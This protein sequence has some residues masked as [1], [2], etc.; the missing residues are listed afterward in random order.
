MRRTFNWKLAVVLVIATGLFTFGVYHLWRWQKH[1]TAVYQLEQGNLAYSQYDWSGAASHYG[2]YLELVKDDAE[3][4]END[5]QLEQPIDVTLRQ[6]RAIL[7]LRPLKRSYVE[8]V[9]AIYR[10][11]LRMD[12]NNF[13]A[14]ENL[15]R[16]YFELNMPAEAEFVLRKYADVENSVEMRLLLAESLTRQR[17]IA[18]SVEML[19]SIVSEHPEQVRAYEMLAGIIERSTGSFPFAEPDSWLTRAIDNNPQSASARVARGFYYLRNGKKKEAIS[20]FAAAGKMNLSE[21]VVRL[22][23]AQGL[24]SAGEPDLARQHLELVQKDMPEDLDVWKSWAKFA[25]ASESKE[26]MF[27]VAQQGLEKLSYQPLDFMPVAAELYIEAG[28]EDLAAELLKELS[29]RDIEPSAVEYMNGL[30]AMRRGEDYQ[31]IK[32]WKRSIENGGDTAKCRLKIAAA[33]AELGDEHSAVKQ[34][35][36]LVAERPELVNARMNLA[37]LLAASARLDEAAEQTQDV[38]IAEPQAIEPELLHIYIRMQQYAARKI[39]NKHP[40]WQELGQRLDELEQTEPDN[41]AIKELKVRLAMQKSEWQTAKGLLKQIVKEQRTAEMDVAEAQLLIILGKPDEAGLVL[42]ETIKRNPGSVEP[43]RLL[44]ALAAEKGDMEQCESLLIDA[45]KNTNNARDRR[46]IV[47]LASAMYAYTGQEAKRSE[48]VKSALDKT[49]DDIGLMRE[50]I[51]ASL[52]DG[53]IE[54]AQSLVELIKDIDSEQWQWRYEQAKVWSNMRQIEMLYPQIVSTL[55]ENLSDNPDDQASRML[56]A[57]TYE[58]AGQLKLAAVTC[59]DILSEPAADADIIAQAIEILYHAREYSY[60]DNVVSRMASQRAW[61]PEVKVIEFRSYL[62]R[63]KFDSAVDLL[64]DILAMNDAKGRELSGLSLRVG[65]KLADEGGVYSALLL[66]NEIVEKFGNAQAYLIRAQVYN[67]LGRPDKAAEDF[68]HAAVLEPDNPEVL[69]SISR[70]YY[71][72]GQVENAVRRADKVLELAGEDVDMTTQAVVIL[73]GSDDVQTREKAKGILDDLLVRHPDDLRLGLC[74]ARYLISQGTNSSVDKAEQMLLE[75]T[76]RYTA[77]AEP[78]ALLTEISLRRVEIGQ[79]M[80]RVMEG[81]TRQSEDKQLLELKALTEAKKSKK[82]AIPTLQMLSELYPADTAVVLSL[83]DIYLETQQPAKAVEILTSHAQSA[84]P[85]RERRQLDIKTAVAFYRDGKT[86]LA[87]EMLT[88]MCA[89]SVADADVI[90]ARA[91][92]MIDEQNWERLD[93]YVQ[94]WMRGYPDDVETIIDIACLLMNTRDKQAEQ[95]AG[96]LLERIVENKPDCVEAMQPLA[97]YYYRSDM[98]AKA[99]EL[100]RLILEIEPGDSSSVNNLCWILSEHDK[101]YSIAMKLAEEALAKSPENSDLID[102]RGMIYY[103][104]GEYEK[105]AQ[106]FRA[107]LAASRTGSR[108]SLLSRFHLGKALAKLGQKNDAVE[109]LNKALQQQEYIG[110]LSVSDITEI[111]NLIDDLSSGA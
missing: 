70:F 30:L 72:N 46:E 32:Y 51:D 63:G 110:G 91:E 87:A 100:Y 27:A 3:L 47:R 66:C 45:L 89:G 99:T 81:L 24:L 75:I 28:R 37:R 88:Q 61:S 43:V 84:R 31:A 23:L 13:Q 58:R 93:R 57:R 29:D 73:L 62:Q 80:Q 71:S 56:L 14:A 54:E 8:R 26:M 50:L 39:S 40:A 5:E 95:A 82:L 55:K 48:L 12:T 79:A 52:D 109:N 35:R 103:R 38:M 74:S 19:E 53:R 44:A 64:Q 4:Y 102:T 98:Y 97:E 85:G 101:Q 25:F 1:R 76:Q 33:L 105:A 78:W 16:I 17:K 10:S 21:P 77:A 108:S 69:L 15:S 60:A 6:A 36:M 92:L 106:D 18:P 83:A 96:K 68:E 86:G 90:I 34:L 104:M 42:N 49:G 20:D 67:E 41:P 94:D 7:N 111:K 65:T 9:T 22:R 11:V 2:R 59:K 107:G